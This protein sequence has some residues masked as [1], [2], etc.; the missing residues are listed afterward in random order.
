MVTADNAEFQLVGAQL[1]L[2]HPPGFPLY[3]LLSHAQTWLPIGGS[4]ADKINLLSAELA[5]ITIVLLY[6][7]V[8]KIGRSVLAGVISAVGLGIS[9]TFWVQTSW[10]NIRTP[11]ALLTVALFLWLYLYHL[12]GRRRWLNLWA[13]SLGL[14]VSHHLSLVFMGV[15]M[16]AWVAW[17]DRQAWQKW[18]W[19][20][21]WGI[22]GLTPWL[23]LPWHDP[24]LRT[25]GEFWHYALGLG[26]GNDFFY[27]VQPHL[28]WE[29]SRIVADLFLLQFPLL[30]WAAMVWG[31]VQLC[32]QSWRFGGLTILCWFVH[33]LV[34]AMY[35]APQ[36]IEYLLPSYVVMAIWLG[37]GFRPITTS[38]RWQWP[39]LALTMIG[40]S[41]TGWQNQK[42]VMAWR[43]IASAELYTDSILTQAPANAVILSNWHWV[44]PLWYEQKINGRRP[45]LQIDYVN[46]DRPN[47]A[48]SWA[49]RIE[50]GKQQQRAM[51]TTNHYQPDSAESIGDAFL[52]RAT[53]LN[54]LP[55]D[56]RP[57]ARS[58]A[59]ALTLHGYKVIDQQTID[60]EID[61]TV[62]WSAEQWPS[63]PVSLFIHLVDADGR[64]AGQEDRIVTPSEAW[65]LSSFRITPHYGAK[66][67]SY[68]LLVG[69]YT[70]DGNPLLA[71]G[72]KRSLLSSIALSEGQDRPFTLHPIW[73][74]EKVGEQQLIGYDIDQTVAGQTRLYLHWQNQQG[75]WNEAIDSAETTVGDKKISSAE[76][77]IPCH[78][79]PLGQGMI[80][81]GSESLPTTLSADQTVRL[82]QQFA[83]SRPMA[84][85]LAVSVS[86][87]GWANETE[88]GWHVQADGIPAMGA[89][90]TLKWLADWRIRDP[91][92]LTVSEEATSGQKVTASVMIYDAFTNRPN[93]ILDERITALGQSIPV[94]A[95][96]IATTLMP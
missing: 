75:Y 69:A 37:A 11:T 82:T 72:E 9:I 13:L 90:P 27:F 35:R 88:W 49:W 81:L 89:L 38:T 95:S 46:P 3:T 8:W 55:T 65:Q 33:T 64:L 54:A 2:A 57:M 59:N 91:H 53:P 76:C 34:T 20:I 42:R 68:Q 73:P 36:T 39:I 48:D 16:V 50:A 47:Y 22:L 28:L 79:V 24:H 12:D 21:F 51:I 63:Q 87:V 62:A 56:F 6:V 83:T 52:Y 5:I 25:W 71:N 74:P 41:V 96:V 30:L 80:W 58:F 40:L 7:L 26:F 44:T 23:Y 31:V 17:Q 19:L 32:R 78:Y 70:A 1:G 84:T 85:D 43:E 60:R 10:A 66:P 86:L 94:G 18:G 4:V 92:W 93:P 61:V 15:C 45:D 29:R 14:A 67:G 77:K